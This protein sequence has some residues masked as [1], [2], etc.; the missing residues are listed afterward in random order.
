MSMAGKAGASPAMDFREGAMSFA[1]TI[2][3][4]VLALAVILY[5]VQVRLMAG[6]DE[7]ALHDLRT[8]LRR[9]RSLLRPLGKVEG[10]SALDAAASELARMAGPARDLEVLAKELERCGFVRAAKMRISFL[11]AL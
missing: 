2:V 6:T 7:E 10:V 9:L 8:C 4:R 11:A 3:A 5:H 1:D